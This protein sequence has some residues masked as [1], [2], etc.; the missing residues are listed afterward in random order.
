V[1]WYENA[2]EQ[3][4]SQAKYNLANY[5][6][7]HSEEPKNV[8]RAVALLERAANLEYD[9]AKYNLALL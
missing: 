6:L 8:S 2:A 1:T 7:R 3:G 9:D 4:D 5:Y